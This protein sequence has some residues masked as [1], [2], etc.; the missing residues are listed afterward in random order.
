[1]YGPGVTLRPGGTGIAVVRGRVV[2]L[3]LTGSTSS[4]FGSTMLQVT[5]PPVVSGGLSN[6]AVRLVRSD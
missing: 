5:A 1:V 2:V 6:G 4:F 3:A